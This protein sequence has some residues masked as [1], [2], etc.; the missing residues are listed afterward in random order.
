LYTPFDEAIGHYRRYTKQT[1]A[2]LTPANL[3]LLRLFYLD[4]V[5]LISSL[6][7]RLVLK[8]ALP[9]PQQIAVWD[10]LL[11]RLSRIVDPL[12]AHSLGKS[13]VGVWRKKEAGSYESLALSDRA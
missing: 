2:E 10:K 7:N 8:H 4:A 13:V 1:L 11:V 3:E 12:L 5:G 9:S 6:G